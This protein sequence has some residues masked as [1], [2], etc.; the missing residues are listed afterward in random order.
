[1][2]KP[3]SNRALWN[4][5][6]RQGQEDLLRLIPAKA[7]K[8]LMTSLILR[9]GSLELDR[10]I[11]ACRLNGRP[12]H[13]TG[14]EYRLLEFLLLHLGEVWSRELLMRHVWRREPSSI[15]L[16]AVHIVSLR[17]KLGYGIL[18]TVYGQG[19]TI[20]HENNNQWPGARGRSPDHRS[21]KAQL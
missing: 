20:D 18:R 21:R 5:V 16:I 19:Y 6:F 17:K 11:R 15:N 4:D 10:L 1:M 8:A 14:N 9:H 3:V 7:A 2:A 12:C 13:L